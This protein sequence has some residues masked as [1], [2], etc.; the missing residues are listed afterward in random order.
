MKTL[1]YESARATI[2]PLEHV[3]GLVEWACEM[4]RADLPRRRKTAGKPAKFTGELSAPFLPRKDD[5]KK[6]MIV[7]V[8]GK[9]AARMQLTE[10]A[11]E[12]RCALAT[13]L[14]ARLPPLRVRSTRVR[15]EHAER[16][17]KEQM[18]ARGGR[19]VI[20]E[21]EWALELT[22]YAGRQALALLGPKKPMIDPDACLSSVLDALQ[23]VGVLDDD[24]RVRQVSVRTE[25]RK[26]E[27][28]LVFILRRIA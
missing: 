3:E 5:H 23:F 25:Y 16:W 27:P 15:R 21:G 28:G 18:R 24:M 19:A 4:K 26:G 10:R 20:D 12:F 7:R 2:A 11:Y 17:V 14:G 6:P 8:N 1:A 22:V 13:K 9:P